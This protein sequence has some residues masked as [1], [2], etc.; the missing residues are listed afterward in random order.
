MNQLWNVLFGAVRARAASIWTM[1]RL[2]ISPT[3]W[4]TRGITMLRSFFMRLLDVKPRHKKDYYS[5]LSWLVS[6]RLAFALVVVIGVVSVW[7]VFAV[8]PLTPRIGAADSTIPT[9]HYRSPALKFYKGEVRILDAE[10]RDA[11]IG[12]V[13]GGRANGQGKL[14][15]ER[16]NLMY[17]GAFND[18]MYEGQ[19]ETYY[20]SGT[21]QYNGAFSR[22]LFHGVGSYFRPEGTL[23]YEGEHV[24]GIRQGAGVLYNAGGNKIFS[25]HFRKARIVYEEFIGKTAP[26]T[27]EMYTG[28]GVT[29][30]EDV[31][32]CVDM[33]EIGAVY[34]ARSGADSVDEEW[35]VERIYVLSDTILLGGREMNTI[36]DVAAALGEATYLGETR[37]TMSDA[38]AANL[39]PAVQIEAVEMELRREF[40]D[41]YTVTS[42]DEN[43]RMH[44]YVFKNDEF[45]YTFYCES[46]SSPGFFMYSAE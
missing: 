25:G 14:Y 22:N 17:S 30:T 15:D 9:Y 11:F 33:N 35:R 43:R 27:A 16:G 40:E 13:S 6:K 3:F 46:A 12:A 21:V 42:Y 31:S 44:I 2:I 39:S 28:A 45:T 38:V 1:F 36:N 24:S 20:P 23:E 34:S 7:Y 32:Y 4:A 8:S 5:F 26:E 10:D 29:Y 19:G 37:L 18:S 41:A